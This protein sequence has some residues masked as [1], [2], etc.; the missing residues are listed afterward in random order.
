MKKFDELVRPDDRGI[1]RAR[2]ADSLDY[3]T[4]YDYS[5]NLKRI[6]I[7]ILFIN[8]IKYEY[9]HNRNYIGICAAR[10]A[11]LGYM[12]RKHPLSKTWQI[13]RWATE[14][15]LA[16]RYKD[17]AGINLDWIYERRPSYWWNTHYPGKHTYPYK[18]RAR[19]A[20]P[21]ILFLNWVIDVLIAYKNE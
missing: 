1:L 18:D 6:D 8:R 19:L 11:A 12:N 3:I 2:I 14:G 13:A 21:R 4:I 7:L 15:I 16:G 20:K 10:D 17:Y 5:N 9:L